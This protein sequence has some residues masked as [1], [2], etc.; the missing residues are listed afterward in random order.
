MSVT[1]D[2]ADGRPEIHTPHYTARIDRERLLADVVE[3]TAA[4]G[5]ACASSPPSTRSPDRTRRSASRPWS[6]NSRRV[7]TGD[8]DLREHAWASR[9]QVMDF[10]PDRITFHAAVRGDGRTHHGAAARRRAVPR[11]LL[12]SGTAHRTVFS[13]NPDHPWR[14]A[15][16]AVEPAVISVNGEGGE[17]GVGRWLFTPAPTCFGLS[18]NPPATAG[19]AGRAVADA[20]AGRRAPHL[21]R[22]RLRPDARRLQPVL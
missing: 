3:R 19:R 16:P 4:P 14:I 9:T 20:R 22:L 12:P 6:T 18:R 13:P 10:R 21:R 8:H 2:T 11:G 17:P 7:R 1:L 5:G 15:R